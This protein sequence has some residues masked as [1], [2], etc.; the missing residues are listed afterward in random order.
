MQGGLQFRPVYN[1]SVPK[2]TITK[3]CYVEEILTK[4]Q[5]IAG[6][7]PALI[8]TCCP[9]PPS[10]LGL[11]R[12]RTYMGYSDVLVCMNGLRMGEWVQVTTKTETGA[13]TTIR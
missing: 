8:L 10:N 12:A 5:N 6:I 1:E 13:G 9:L 4:S 2:L 11:R 3:N 7:Q